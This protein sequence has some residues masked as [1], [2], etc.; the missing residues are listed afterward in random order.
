MVLNRLRVAL[1]DR[2]REP[3]FIETVPRVGYR[4]A[5]PVVELGAVLS[6]PSPSPSQRIA[7]YAVVAAGAAL[8]AL[9]LVRQHYDKLVDRRA[10]PPSIGA[11]HRK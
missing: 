10:Q 6:K 7:W 8:L 11:E 5:S 2:G 4:F 3:V 9:I 1:G